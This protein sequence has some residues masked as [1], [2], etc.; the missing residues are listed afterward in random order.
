[1]SDNVEINDQL[2][3]IVGF[4][5]AGKS[6]SLRN[7]RNQERWVY[8][9]TEAGKRLPFKNNFNNVRIDDPYDILE[10]FDQCTHPDNIDSVDGIIIDSLTF[11]MD[12]L[13]SKYIIPATNT[14]KA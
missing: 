1:M 13:E 3:L 6:A 8:L 14:Q 5:S 12:M 7:I 11:M 10:Y 4:S 9:N 2:I